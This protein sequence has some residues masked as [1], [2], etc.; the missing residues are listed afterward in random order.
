[1]Q[2]AQMLVTGFRLTVSGQDHLDTTLEI[3][4]LLLVAFIFSLFIILV[5][6]QW[7]PL[8]KFQIEKKFM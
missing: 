2:I 5:I 8:S 3:L 1:M 7:I 4:V 6:T